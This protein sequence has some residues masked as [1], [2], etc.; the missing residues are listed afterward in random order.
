[1]SKRAPVK[2]VAHGAA[3]DL[4]VAQQEF[5]RRHIIGDGRAMGVGIDQIFQRDAFG[6]YIWA[7]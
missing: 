2:R 3:F 7:S 6:L 1:M 5:F 4:A